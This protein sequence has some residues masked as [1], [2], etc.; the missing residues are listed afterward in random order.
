MQETF[1]VDA[2]VKRG[3]NSNS[4]IAVL[5]IAILFPIFSQAQE[6][7]GLNPTSMKWRKF[8][9][10][11]GLFVYPEGMDSFAY[12]AAAIIK[13]QRAN[14]WQVHTHRKT[15][16][17]PVIIQNQSS[18]PQGF[19]VPAPWRVEIFTVSPQNMFLG[20]MPWFDGVTSHEYRHAQQFW[21]AN[22]GFTRAYQF[23]MGETGWLLNALMAQPLWFREG[24]AVQ[25]E[26]DLTNGGRGRFPSFNMEWRAV[27]NADIKY[28]YDKGTWF[29]YRDFVPNPYRGGYHMV[30]YARNMFGDS[31]WTDVLHD[32]YERTGMFWPFARA[33]KRHTGM[34]PKD[35]YRATLDSIKED[36]DAEI[37]ALDTTPYFLASPSAKKF[38][39]YRFPQWQVDGGIVAEVT[40]FDKIRTIV[41]IDNQGEAT[42]LTTPG[43]YTTDHN[44]FA[45]GFRYAA[46]SE[47][48]FHPRWV[49]KDWSVL[50]VYDRV[51][52]EKFHLTHKT[53]LYSPS[54]SPDSEH[55]I[56]VSNSAEGEVQL[57]D[58]NVRERYLNQAFDSPGNDYLAHPTWRDN[59][60]KILF[61]ALDEKGNSIQ[62]LDRRT[63]KV[64]TLLHFSHAPI[65]RP[66]SA[67]DTI[68]FSGAPGNT[69]EIFA[70]DIRTQKIY[71]LTVS[72]F[73]AFE[74]DI[75]DDKR[76]LAYSAFTVNGYQIRKIG[77]EDLAW[78]EVDW[79]E[80]RP[81]AILDTLPQEEYESKKFHGLTQGLGRI[82]GHFI[83]PNIVEYGI[84]FYTR[85]IMSNWLGTVG[86]VYN[87]NEKA[88][89]GY[90]RVSYAGL[91]PI[92]D[93][94]GTYGE[95]RTFDLPTTTI[96]GQL[97]S[98]DMRWDERT[99]G[100]FVRVPLNLTRGPYNRRMNFR[101]GY[102]AYEA[103]GDPGYDWFYNIPLNFAT[104]EG[105]FSFSNM[106]RTV[107]QNTRPRWGQE[108]RVIMKEG[109]LKPYD[110]FAYRMVEGAL[111][112][113]GLARTH[114]LRLS[115]G[116]VEHGPS[117]Y[118]FIDQFQHSR[119]YNMPLNWKEGRLSA[120]YQF[121]VW[122]PDIPLGGWALVQ[123]LRMN[124]FYDHGALNSLR[125]PSMMRS[126]GGELLVDAKVLRLFQMVMGMRF[127]YLLDPPPGMNAPQFQIF[128]SQ[129]EF[130]N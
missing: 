27:L 12:R 125:Y 13:Y 7:I 65:S 64:D 60:W 130:S 79:P 98:L 42:D 1:A 18:L 108:I 74:P 116:Y 68:Y 97:D 9:T 83:L 87:L 106:Q 33:L 91:W 86:G 49:N 90:A 54:F 34:K 81:P 50:T 73:G 63:K 41:E 21:A 121:P 95:R 15:R 62:Q 101:F 112:F 119:G 110:Y 67:G 2:M 23:L 35:L 45:E 39:S 100:I 37:A 58:F 11:T 10:E 53:R 26:T 61:I 103:W 46:W 36:I 89:R 38:T 94:E 31:I 123:R 20:P 30:R 85:N 115:G 76:W 104:L 16:K 28:P 120:E 111:N 8:K 113:P 127:S 122:Y 43:I 66:V 55:L 80:S 105:E 88:F 102:K 22:R 14:E 78:K 51:L 129:F 25:T 99:L 70:L 52:N 114:S 57:M 93:F 107:R 117:A 126:F 19:A 59:G 3:L 56:A 92:F 32:T 24:D 5:L 4:I 17:V 96:T 69:N 128:V 77:L 75:S 29:S 40:G 84:E 72:K 47:S 124:L 71:Q 118:R 44:S 109:I 82:T 6:A 48:S